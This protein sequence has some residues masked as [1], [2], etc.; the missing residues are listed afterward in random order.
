MSEEVGK[1]ERAVMPEEPRGRDEGFALV[2]VVKVG[3]VAKVRAGYL[4]F[5]KRGLTTASQSIMYREADRTIGS[6][7]GRGFFL[8]GGLYCTDNS[9]RLFRCLS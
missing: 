6:C 8:G 5:P 4:G 1:V 3:P 2:L 7:R 9:S